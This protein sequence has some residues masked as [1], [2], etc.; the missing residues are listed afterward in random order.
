M[1]LCDLA[2]A[3]LKSSF[4]D[5]LDCSETA[6]GY[7]ALSTPMLY[8]DRDHIQ[9]Y[10]K[11]LSGGRFLVSDLGQTMMKLSTYGFEPHRTPR[12]R[13]M[14]FQITASTGVKYDNGRFY[15]IASEEQLGSK[16]WDLLLGLHKVSNLVFT[17]GSYTKATFSDEFENFV[18]EKQIEYERG[19]Q[20]ELPIGTTESVDFWINHSSNPKAVLLLSASTPGYAQQRSDRV[21]RTFNELSLADYKAARLSVID[22]RQDVWSNN[23]LIRLNHVSTVIPWTQTRVLEQALAVAN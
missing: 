21:Y 3:Q 13:A 23:L 2:L 5:S 20:L 19:K 11:Q 14:I 12:R 16:I 9:L 7:Y 18:A 4:S 1:S 8:P 10:I 17:V 22:D 15:I 6:Y